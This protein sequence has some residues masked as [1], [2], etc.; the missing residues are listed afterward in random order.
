MKTLT[1]TPQRLQQ[2]ISFILE[3]D[4]LKN[5]I[6]QSYLV[7]G[8]RRENSAEHSWH[9]AMMALLLS[10]YTSAHQKEPIDL[11]KV[12]K[13]LLIH[14]IVEI[15][16]GDTFAYD[17][18]GALDK[19]EREERAAERLFGLLPQEQ[20]AEFHDIWREF[21]EQASADAKFATA[22]DRLM[23]LLHNYHTEG[24]GWK[25][26]NIVQAQV[27]KRNAHIAAGS[28][29]LWAYA[30]A[31]IRDSVAKGYLGE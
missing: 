2:Q 9:L 16:A 1:D 22:L 26:H 13:M 24:I 15:D 19:V 21:E 28:E 31:I 17:E 12:L 18:V 20:Q 14:D 30:Q 3:I 29:T 25:K 27:L 5:I 23:P 4:K 11:L 8:E 7:N 10:E 6:R